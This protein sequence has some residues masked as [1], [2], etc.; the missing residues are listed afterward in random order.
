M[1]PTSHSQQK[2][3]DVVSSYTEAC[4]V[5]YDKSDQYH[6]VYNAVIQMTKMANMKNVDEMKLQ[7]KR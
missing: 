4:Q 1:D 3:N 7:D 6:Q 2:S 5:N